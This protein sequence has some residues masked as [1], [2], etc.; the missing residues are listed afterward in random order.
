M[1][2][3]NEKNKPYRPHF[4]HAFFNW[5]ERL[6]LPSW[7]STL[8]LFPLI[9]IVQHLVAYQR[10]FLL[11]GE[12]NFD[13]ATAGYWIAG[14]L[15]IYLWSVKGSTK[16]WEDI[17]PLFDPDGETYARLQYAFFTIPGRKGTLIFWVGVLAGIQNGLSDK[18]VAPAVDYAFAE[19]RL[20][21][22]ALG[23]ATISLIIY[24]LI[25]QL[26]VIKTLYHQAEHVDIFNQQPL[27]GFPVFTAVYVFI[28]LL[29]VLVAPF[30]LD[31]TAFASEVVLYVSAAF[32]P[33]SLLMFYSPLAGMHSRLRME[34]EALQAEVGNRIRMILRQIHQAAFD[35][36]NYANTGSMISVH[37][38]LLK[39]K[40]A[41][42]DLST[43][44][45]RRGTFSGLV[46][47][48]LF[49]I[50]LSILRDVISGWIGL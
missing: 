48:L 8:L 36:K 44:P 32:V 16:A 31:P 11:P 12:I 14:P 9:G 24:Q 19:L 2:A 10:G 26:G 45:W 4:I 46:T 18:A 3:N 43:W 7:L 40:E 28:L 25:R 35:E 27:Y 41:I 47:A 42:N 50:T 21:I 5:L 49:P 22:W 1:T 23:A 37:A 30:F 34:K 33:I 39:E 29:F 13:L 6:P 15:L 20:T 17:R 38:V